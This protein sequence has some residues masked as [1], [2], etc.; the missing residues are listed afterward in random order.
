MDARSLKGIAVV[1]IAQGEKLG[2]VDEVVIDTQERRVGALRVGSGGLLRKDRW[3]VPFSSIERIGSDA[4]MVE[5]ERALH[6][7]YQTRETGYH[8]LD[9]IGGMRVVTDGGTYLGNIAT[10]HFD[11]LTGHLTEF[12]IG[13]GGLG[14]LFGSSKVV[15]AA[16]VVS[17]GQD[18]MVVPDQLFG[19]GQDRTTAVDDSQTTTA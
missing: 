12:E 5:N 16:A 9:T 1:S 13:H 6:Q 2:A 8:S 11:E 3:Y 15:S 17:I 14:G 19:E 10:V 7:S 18:I 4:V